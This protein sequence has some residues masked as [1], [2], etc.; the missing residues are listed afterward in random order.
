MLD[1]NIAK[2]IKN[3]IIRLEAVAEQVV[4]N[5]FWLLK[6]QLEQVR[7]FHPEFKRKIYNSGVR[8]YGA[9]KNGS[10]Y[11]SLTKYDF[12]RSKPKLGHHVIDTYP[13]R[14]AYPYYT[15][16]QIAKHSHHWE[17]EILRNTRDILSRLM[18]LIEQYKALYRNMTK[19]EKKH[20]LFHD[21]IESAYHNFATNHD[22]ILL[23]SEWQLAGGAVEYPYR[24]IKGGFDIPR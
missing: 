6:R 20:E 1:L 23:D 14:K 24:H 9:K 11:I 2:D 3:S 5:G 4:E 13:K 22:F 17:Q 18:F 10:Y 21:E 12:L 7:Y 19:I 8:F 15:D 16:A